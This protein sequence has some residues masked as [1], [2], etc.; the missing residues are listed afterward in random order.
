MLKEL[1]VSTVIAS[2]VFG[3]G[4]SEPQKQEEINVV[5]AKVQSYHEEY[6]SGSMIDENGEFWAFEKTE[7]HE[8]SDYKIIYDENWVVLAL[9]EDGKVITF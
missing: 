6:H 7:L 8:D 3:C 4:C 5:S 1:L 9:V 2:T